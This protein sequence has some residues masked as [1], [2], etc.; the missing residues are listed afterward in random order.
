VSG[1][2]NPIRLARAIL[3][4]GRHVLLVGD[5][6]RKY[7]ERAGLE[8]CAADFLTTE[9]QRRRWEQ[10]LQEQG[11]NTVGA[12]AVDAAGHVAAATSTGGIARKLA[13]RVGDSAVIGAGTYADDRAGAV[14]ATGSGEAIMRCTL[15]RAVADDL[16][17]GIDPVRASESALHALAADVGGDAGLIAID[18]FGRIGCARNTEYMP[19][20]WL[21]AGLE[22]PLFSR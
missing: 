22:H 7:A 20:A 11:G 6:A 18:P 14:S 9:R 12:V 3:D 17:R 16:R 19:V 21:H 2:R 15:A 1:V 5:S 10:S 8:L 13:G 4:E